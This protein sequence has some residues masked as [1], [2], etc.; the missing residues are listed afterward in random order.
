MTGHPPINRQVARVLLIDP[1]NR[2]LLFR[3]QDPDN[4]DQPADWYLP[5]GGMHDGETPA[6][7]ARRELLDEAAIEDVEIGPVVARLSGVR[8]Q[9][10][11]RT[12]EQDE[13]H[14]LA[15]AADDQVGDG[16]ADD[17]VAAAVL[18]HR[19]WSLDDLPGSNETVG[20]SPAS[21]GQHRCPR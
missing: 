18:A 9:F 2:V 16:R 19:W 5:G 15:W 17:A 11:G 12:F 1:R 13:W 10:G 20:W 4:P 8:F 3:A 6:Q 7:A 14:P 21:G